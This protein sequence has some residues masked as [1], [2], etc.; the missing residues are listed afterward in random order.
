MA[1]P[2][3]R[4]QLTLPAALVCAA[5]MA[6]VTMAQAQSAPPAGDEALPEVLVTAQRTASL[7]SKT[8]V[9]MT[10]LS[11]E[12]LRQAGLDHPAD[13]GARVPGV[14][15]DGAAD[16]LRITMR[17][18]SNADSTEKG[19]PSAAFM[20]DGIYIARPQMLDTS[21]YDLARV[22]VLRGPQGTLYGRNTTAGVVNVI[23]NVPGAAREGAA[24]V[25]LG[26]YNSRKAKARLNVPLSDTLALR[27]ALA[28]ARHDP[29]LINGQGT[30]YHLGME[31]DDLAGR[32]SARL[33]ITPA[34][35][36]LLR[37]DHSSQRNNND[38]IVPVTNFYTLGAS[39]PAWKD[40]STSERLSFRFV[41]PNAP[42]QQG[43]NRAVTTGVGAEFDWD[44]G[45]LSVHY[46][47]S[48]RSFDHDF[49]ANFYYQLAPTFAIGVRHDFSGQYR[50]DSHE[51]RVATSAKGPLTA[52]A[53]LYYFRETGDV[54][55]RFRDLELLGLT[56]Y[57]VFPHQAAA[58]GRAVFGQ[59]TWSFSERLRATAGVRYSDDDKS[60]V[61]ST[62][63]QQAAAFNPATDLRLLNDA[64]LQTH[65]T[66]WRLGAEVDA[67]PGTLLFGSVSTG[68]KAGGFNDGC[69]A[70]STQNGIACPASIA[71]PASALLYQPETLTAYEA[72]LKTR[73]WNKRASLQASVFHYDY[74]NLQLSGVVIV[75]GAPRF[76][77]TNAGQAKVRGLEIEGQLAATPVD[78]LSYSLALLDAHYTQYRPDGQ[79]SWAG[80]K[81]DRSPAAA[82]TVGLEHSF[83]FDGARLQAGLFARHSASYLISVPSALVQYRIPA[84]TQ[85]DASVEYRP[86]HGNWSVRALVKNIDNKIQPIAIDSFGMVVP[87]DPRTVG[88][89]VDVHF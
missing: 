59:A 32:L 42:P 77:T 47:G 55:Y 71:V 88:V 14:H 25:E 7:A 50:Q 5:W 2:R 65:K 45:A 60:R 39:G 69:L 3:A 6:P 29:Y 37:L 44:L 48:H 74:A 61:G 87:S 28:Y 19:D 36:L 54:L 56:P 1:N 12:Q 21:F 82:A 26:N 31:R 72:G 10:V 33:A 75:Q 41:P 18:V 30:G 78:K 11:G 70:G 40:G 22:E 73:F 57:Y 16:G 83:L 89:R 79:V 8:P 46:L 67:A 24:S 85:S 63:F 23:A 58:V 53:G 52:Q 80:R 66:T 38:S 17:G 68:Y 62:N 43:K 81:L 34:A 76:A 20:L 64:A 9:S 49:L 4:W 86:E 35:S 84:R 51:L 13:I 27:A 15:L